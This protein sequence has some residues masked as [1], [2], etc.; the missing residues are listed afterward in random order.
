MITDK[1]TVMIRHEELAKLIDTLEP[2]AKR[3]KAPRM[4]DEALK[5]IGWYYGQGGQTRFYKHIKTARPDR[6]NSEPGYF[7]REFLEVYEYGKKYST[8]PE[9]LEMLKRQLVRYEPSHDPSVYS[10]DLTSYVSKHFEREYT[11]AEFQILKRKMLAQL[12][13]AIAFVEGSAAGEI[14]DYSN[15]DVED[16]ESA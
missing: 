2:I 1:T 5:A 14:P 3:Y 13:A 16:R 9:M 15:F 8:L 4:A 6:Y 10:G 11:P 7:E 12:R